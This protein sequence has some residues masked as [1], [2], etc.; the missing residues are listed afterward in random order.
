M[1][2][3]TYDISKNRTRTKF[4]KFLSKYGR[5]LQFSVFEIKNSTRVLDKILAEIE[6]KYKKMFEPSDSILIWRLTENEE[7]RII[8]Y[9]YAV[10]EEEDLIIFD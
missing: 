10:H 6:M 2:I 9:G 4:S 3:L 8:R 5:R 1:I 7:K